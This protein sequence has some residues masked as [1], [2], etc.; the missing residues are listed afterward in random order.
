MFGPLPPANIKQLKKNKCQKGGCKKGGINYLIKP[1]P[2][3]ALLVANFGLK[4]TRSFI[5]Q[6][7]GMIDAGNGIQRPESEHQTMGY[8]IFNI[9]VENFRLQFFAKEKF[10]YEGF[11]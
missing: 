11:A 10:E 3:V 6:L 4:L 8:K 7:F 9:N 1:K 2:D 5:N